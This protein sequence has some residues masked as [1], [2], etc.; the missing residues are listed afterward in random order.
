MRISIEVSE[1]GKVK[2]E[3]SDDIDPISAAKLLAEACARVLAPF[4]AEVKESPKIIKPK[5]TIPGA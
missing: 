1:D 2:F 5:L 3:R 4:K